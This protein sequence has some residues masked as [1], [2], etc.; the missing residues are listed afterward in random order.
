MVQRLTF[1]LLFN[2][3]SLPSEIGLLKELLHINLQE[4]AIQTLPVEMGALTKVLTIDLSHNSLRS[5]PHE[6][7]LMKSLSWLDIS[8][9]GELEAASN[10]ISR[11]HR[12]LC[13]GLSSL[14]R[15]DL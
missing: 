3:K 9:L 7:C 1:G 5:L 13:H 12:D 10:E 14:V 6:F 8:N 2:A 11:F 4:N 15:L